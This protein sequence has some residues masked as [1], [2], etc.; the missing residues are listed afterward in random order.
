[1]GRH[2][3]DAKIQMESCDLTARPWDVKY[4]YW[5]AEHG[6]HQYVVVRQQKRGRHVIYKRWLGLD[7][8]AQVEPNAFVYEREEPISVRPSPRSESRDADMELPILTQPKIVP[9][10]RERVKR[11][12]PYLPEEEVN[13]R[14]NVSTSKRVSS[15]KRSRVS[16]GSGLED[17]TLGTPLEEST[18]PPDHVAPLAQP[19]KLSDVPHARHSLSASLTQLD[20]ASQ[21]FSRRKE[22]RKL[23][24][25]QI[26]QQQMALLNDQLRE[27]QEEENEDSTMDTA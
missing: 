3:R 18:R 12:S 5:I 15:W 26:R 24:K 7:S 21:A 1:M 9:P 23:K 4:H 14:D 17:R 16:S 20:E 13:I 27:L 6:G 11:P 19:E 2:P 22:E 10:S 25:Q 8:S